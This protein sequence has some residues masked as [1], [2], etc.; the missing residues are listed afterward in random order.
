MQEIVSTYQ[1]NLDLDKAAGE[2][3]RTGKEAFSMKPSVRKE[4][5]RVNLTDEEMEELRQDCGYVQNEELRKK[6][7]SL[8]LKRKKLE[9]LRIEKNWHP[10]PICGILCPPE[11]SCCQSCSLQEK[12]RK[13][14][15]IRKLLAEL[16][17]LRYPEIKK[18]I[19][20]TPEMVDSVREDMLQKLASKV[21]LEDVDSLDACTIVM[22]YLHLPPQNLTEEIVRRT[23]Y[24]LRND[25]A[26]PKEFKPYKRYDVIPWGKKAGKKRRLPDVPSS[27]K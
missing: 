25:L 14:E 21:H 6:I 9:K 15:Q 17:W 24:R 19:P 23:L 7:F 27:R 26:K 18:S 10:C 20:C 3:V 5:R 13:R 12:R 8:S 1:R 4:L 16:P 2:N 11:E 22:L